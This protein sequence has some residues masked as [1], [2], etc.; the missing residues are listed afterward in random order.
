[1]HSNLS[2]HIV[3]FGSDS[4]WLSDIFNAKIVRLH[5]LFAF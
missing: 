4:E 3:A 1:M 2:D 5:Q